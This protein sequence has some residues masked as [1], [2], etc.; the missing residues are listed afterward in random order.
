MNTI[1]FDRDFFYTYLFL[2]VVSILLFVYISYGSICLKPND[3]YIS[4]L[5][6]EF[7]NEIEKVRAEGV[8][9]K[10]SYQSEKPSDIFLDKIYNPLISPSP[11]Y[12][13]HVITCNV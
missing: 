9:K 5:K 7:M 11:V 12:T 2:L 10:N 6:K 3:L 1:C 4:I 13:W 8:L